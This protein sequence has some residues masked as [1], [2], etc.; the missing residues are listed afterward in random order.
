MPRAVLLSVRR[1]RLSRD[2]GG[3]TLVELLVVIVVIAILLAIAVPSYAGFRDR[4]E[5]A[6]AKSALR[7]AVVPIE[8]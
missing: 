8:S 1:A 5:E 3:F 6:A 7:I 4:A 2:P